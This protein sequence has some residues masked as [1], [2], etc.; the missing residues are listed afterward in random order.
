MSEACS[1]KMNCKRAGNAFIC[2]TCSASF[3]TASEID[4]ASLVRVAAQ[5]ESYIAEMQVHE[6][7]KPCAAV[8]CL[9]D[10]VIGILPL[11]KVCQLKQSPS[12]SR[13]CLYQ[14]HI[15]SS[16]MTWML[17][18]ARGAVPPSPCC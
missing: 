6:N 7:Q 15:I 4:V 1:G 10:H 12:P 14:I 9:L 5:A 8:S 17:H 18:L 16:K 3:I 2:V 13:E 11:A